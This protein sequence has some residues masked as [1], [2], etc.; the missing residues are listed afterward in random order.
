ML[1]VVPVLSYFHL[2]PVC[3]CSSLH[4]DPCCV[5]CRYNPQLHTRSTFVFIAASVVSDSFDHCKNLLSGGGGVYT[6]IQCSNSK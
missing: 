1:L 3:L 6:N 5:L 2:L 4:V